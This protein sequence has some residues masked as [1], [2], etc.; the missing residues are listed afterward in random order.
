MPLGSKIKVLVV[1][2][3]ALV[4]QTLSEV[5]SE[6]P[7]IEV[8][9]KAGDPF[10][11]AKIMEEIAP[12]VITLDVEMPRMDGLT[13]LRKI[14][15]QHPIP[16]VICSTL[17]E[18]GSETLMRALD[19]G[20]V[21]I[22]QKPKLGTR[23]FLEESKIRIRDAVKAA[24]SVKLRK[25]SR[26]MEVS[27]KLSADAVLPGVGL[28]A[29]S[30]LQTTEKIVLVGA[31]TGG[32]EALRIF[33]E[34]MPQDCPA[35][36]IVQH[37]PEHFTTAFAKRLDT[38]C[39]INV[40]EAAN[41]D[42]MLRGQALIA[43]GN[44][45][46]L[47]KRSGARYYVEV[48]DGPL[49]RRHRPSVDVLFRSGARYAGKNAVG[50]IM[51]GMGDDGAHGL[52]EMKQAGAFTVAQDEASSVVFG[53]PGEAIK[54]GAAYKVLSLERIAHEVVRFCSSS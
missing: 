39:S 10:A 26:P 2:D 6:D 49:V 45:H 47:V 11:A 29:P 51:T 20:A 36:A 31:S 16:V 33:L 22:I 25:L 12:D 1:D 52:L 44:K 4:R 30:Q 43:P 42:T 24:A 19:Y 9:G 38:I 54:L 18:H 28:N 32:T 17:T 7:A 13:F 21:E 48:R 50:V 34:A 37:M 23:Q 3:S 41:N 8:I 14:M 53:M 46:M 27:P 5:L 15:S 35:I 40:R